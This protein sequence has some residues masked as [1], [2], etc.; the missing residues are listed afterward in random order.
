LAVPSS[1]QVALQRGDAFLA[2]LLG[3]SIHNFDGD[4]MHVMKLRLMAENGETLNADDV[5]GQVFECRYV[6]MKPVQL[7]GKTPGEIDDGIRTVLIAPDY[8]AV[9]FTSKGVAKSMAM[10]LEALG[11]EPFNPAIRLILVK[12]KNAK[13]QPFY[14]LAIAD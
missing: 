9:G 12:G 6:Y 4:K 10:I 11:R 2:S 1:Q 3:D 8:T 7:A 5:S 14:S 13:N